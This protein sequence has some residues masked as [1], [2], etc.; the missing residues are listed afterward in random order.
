MPPPGRMGV[1]YRAPFTPTDVIACRATAA[2]RGWG[3]ALSGK[4]RLLDWLRGTS[5]TVYY[6][7][8]LLCASLS[9]G[10]EHEKRHTTKHGS[11]RAES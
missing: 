9:G 7:K 2:L 6:W 11:R 8:A 3:R 10:S 5:G 4:P 1:P